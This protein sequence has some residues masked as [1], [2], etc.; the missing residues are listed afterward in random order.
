MHLMHSI[1]VLVIESCA[2]ESTL[3]IFNCHR[4]V[5]AGLILRR[6]KISQPFIANCPSYFYQ[7]ESFL[8]GKLR[9]YTGALEHV[10]L[11]S[12]VYQRTNHTGRQFI[13]STLF[14]RRIDEIS[15]DRQWSQIFATCTNTNI[16]ERLHETTNSGAR[17]RGQKEMPHYGRQRRERDTKDAAYQPRA[18]RR[19]RKDVDGEEPPSKTS[20]RNVIASPKGIKAILSHSTVDR[21]RLP[22]RRLF[23][24]N[25]QI[26]QHF[27]PIVFQESKC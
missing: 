9:G 21:E 16:A 25:G 2:S 23:P 12:V 19:G 1:S 13:S 26:S 7:S 8:G 18:Q 3:Y 22:R 15:R 4:L 5:N 10:G 6:S 11:A 14:N 27:L 24:I 17:Q 20:K